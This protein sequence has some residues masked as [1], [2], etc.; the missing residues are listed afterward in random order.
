MRLAIIAAIASAF[1]AA[2]DWTRFRGPNGSGV[3]RDSGYPVEFGKD[4]N[5]VWRTPVRPGKSSPVLSDRHVLLTGFADGK[6]YTQC[7]DRA[8][9]KFLWERWEERARAP[10]ENALNHPAAPSPVTDGTNVYVFFKDF[11][12]VSYDLAGKLRWKVPLGPFTTSMG[13][14]SSPILAGDSVVLVADQLEGSFIAAFD[15]RNGEIRWKTPRDEAEGWA[16]PL[17]FGASS[18]VILTTGR[19]QF[20]AYTPR[21]GKRTATHLGLGTAIVAS[22]VM[23]GD[24]LYAFGYGTEG[25]AP[26]SSR[27]SRL[28]KNKDGKLTTDEFGGDAFVH[29]I[30]KYGGNRDM[31]VT[32]DEWDAKQKEVG[33]PTSLVAL[34]VESGKE[35]GSV[36][37]TELWRF[38]KGFN[39]VIPSPLAYQGVVYVVKNGGI[40]MSF[41]AATGK[42]AKQGRV[43]GALGGYSASPVAAEGRLYL[44]SEEGKVSVLRAG[45]DWSMIAVNDL[46]EPCFATPA[47]SGGHIYLRTDE[48]LYRFGR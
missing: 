26:F 18:P 47:L 7:F 15:R 31:V 9:G 13:L 44:P 42:L 17:L 37:T 43:E 38:E 23:D 28:D 41:D 32:E 14:G 27:L 6:L 22:P 36:R 11:G 40:L 4:K 45:A 24:V 25:P 8:T 10:F 34:R 39:G 16:T 30:A 1:A 19:G 5:M 21:N 3:A 35:P 20:G 33:G 2:E 48:A 46:G 12:M 29:G